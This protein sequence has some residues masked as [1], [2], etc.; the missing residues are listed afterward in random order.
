MDTPPH[1][2]RPPSEI[3]P[4]TAAELDQL[5]AACEAE[6]VCCVDFADVVFCDSS[7]IRVLVQHC[8][9]HLEAG[10]T[11]RVVDVSEKL[12]R[13]FTIAGVGQLFDLGPS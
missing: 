13:V 6:D 12:Q 2:V 8:L 11:L 10:G 1:I 4:S 3:D 5:L 7:G 9:R